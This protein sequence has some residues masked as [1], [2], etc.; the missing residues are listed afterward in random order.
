MPRNMLLFVGEFCVDLVGHDKDIMPADHLRDRLQI[1][2][3]HDR[4]RGVVRERQVVEQM[5]KIHQFAIMCAPTTSQYAAVEAL[6]NGDDDVKE[7]QI[8]ACG[9]ICLNSS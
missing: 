4:P 5:T 9:C 7:I 2:P 6:R 8:L 3:L 1:L